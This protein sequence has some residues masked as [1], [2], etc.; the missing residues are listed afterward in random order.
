MKKYFSNILPL[1]VSS[2]LATATLTF[3]QGSLT[4]P[5]APAPT[6]KSLDQIE[7]RTP[8]MYDGYNVSSPGSY[9]LVTNL[10]G[11]A[12]GVP[13]SPY[14][15][16]IA[17]D[18]VTIDLNGFTLQG[19]SGSYSGIYIYGSH[20]NIIV[21]NGII[22]GWAQ[23]GIGYNYPYSSPQNVVLEHLTVSAN[24]GN[25][26]V[27][28][29]GFTISNCTIQNNQGTGILLDGNGSQVVGN[30]LIGNNA[31]NN[32]NAGAITIE[33]SNNRIEGNH[34]TGSGASGYGIA[35]N[36]GGTTGNIVIKNSVSGNGANNYSPAAG[37]DLG[38]VGTAAASTSPWANIS[39]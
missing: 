27:A 35:L 12:Y 7:P 26:I 18:N 33:G 23:N 17:S 34:V 19:V 5:G 14:G 10:T 6:M 21:R 31:A 25:G 28:A 4:P 32:V 37:N 36:Y 24:V 16:F 8:I 39:H 15:I 20:T 3:A 9:Y 2:L 11:S 1:I 38:P 13:G 22:T 30:I 29:N